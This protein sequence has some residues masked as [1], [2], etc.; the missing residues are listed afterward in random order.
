MFFQ[1]QYL[2][3]SEWS[4]SLEIMCMHFIL[5]GPH[6]SLHICNHIHYKK[7]HYDFPKM[8]GGSKAV[9]IFFQKSIPIWQ[10]DPSLTNVIMMLVKM[11]SITVA[12]TRQTYALSWKSLTVHPCVKLIKIEPISQIS[13]IS[14][15]LLLTCN[16]FS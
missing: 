2:E 8:R 10:P 11:V 1:Q 5:S 4:P 16:F 7:L 9:W 3:K 6:T 14:Q 13:Q 15:I 12:H